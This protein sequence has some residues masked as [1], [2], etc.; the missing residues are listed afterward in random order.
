M[1]GLKDKFHFRFQSFLKK[2]KLSLNTETKMKSFFVC[3]RSR[4]GADL[5]GGLLR[6][7]VWSLSSLDAGVAAHG[8]GKAHR[9]TNHGRGPQPTKSLVSLSFSWLPVRSWS[10]QS[11]ASAFRPSARA[12]GWGGT[13]R[14]ACTPATRCSPTATCESHRHSFCLSAVL[15]HGY[16]TNTQP[17]EVLTAET[18]EEQAAVEVWGV[19]SGVYRTLLSYKN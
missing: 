3:C 1:F 5:G 18:R 9:H 10:V 8:S 12:R 14:S 17:S 16:T 19:Y 4:R 7:L 11:T 13:P 6:P 15:Q 2:W